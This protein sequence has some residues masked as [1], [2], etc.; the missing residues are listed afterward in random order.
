METNTELD[1]EL[2]LVTLGILQDIPTASLFE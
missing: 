1:D 2:L